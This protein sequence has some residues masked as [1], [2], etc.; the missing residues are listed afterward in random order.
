MNYSYLIYFYLSPLLFAIFLSLKN[1]S[2]RKIYLLTYISFLLPFICS[3]I[4]FFEY[5]LN[6]F[7]AFEI[8]LGDLHLSTHHFSFNFF[9]DE[10]SFIILLLTGYLSILV[11]KFSYSYLH[12]ESNYQRFF[13]VINLFVFGLSLL[14]I[15]G[16]LDLFF[17]GWEIIGLSSFLLIGFYYD[18]T[19][20]T[21]NAF[22]IFSVYRL[23]DVGLLFSAILGHVLWDKSDHFYYL[24]NEFENISL[25]FSSQWLVA[26]QLLIILAA[27]GKS[28]QFPFIN[29][30]ARAMEGPTPSSAIFY[31]ALSIHCG[32][33]LLYRTYPLFSHSTLILSLIFTI[34]LLS[35]ILATGIGRVQANIKGQLAYSTVAQIGIMFMEIAL[36]FK[37]LVL[38]H[39]VLHALF[40]CYQILISPSIVVDHIKSMDQTTKPSLKRNIES[41]LPM[42]LKATLFTFGMQEGFLSISERGFFPLPLV[43]LKIWGRKHIYT[44]AMIFSLMGLAVFYQFENIQLEFNQWA[45]HIF[46]ILDLILSLICIFSL[47]HP[48]KIWKFFILAQISFVLAN[49]FHDPEQLQ[50]IGLYLLSAIPCLSLGYF[51]LA[52][53]PTID[54]TKYNGLHN[55]F[56]FAY[57][58]MLVAFVG[59]AGYPFSTIFWAEDIIFAEILL[60]APSILMMTAI[61]LMLNGLIIGKILVK[62]FWGHPRRTYK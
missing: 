34:G 24:I 3:L 36:G 52:K 44:I 1:L 61:S 19:R 51:A 43:E 38:I 57:K 45:A 26:M 23:C 22:R 5:A 42:K 7:T 48:L 25:P 14:A 18:R 55:H 10:L 60:E 21:R 4:F 16:T 30:P 49:Y 53:L 40:R 62:T 28:A 35:T 50:G 46:A 54:L 37:E 47:K 17:A 11:N 56:P 12:R 2:E 8:S 59:L 15:A 31:G 13:L 41:I 32:V 20:P 33:F 6:S 58:L 27:I 39:L 9:F 29:W